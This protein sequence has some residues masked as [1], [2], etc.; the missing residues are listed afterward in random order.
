MECGKFGQRAGKTPPNT[1]NND[2]WMLSFSSILNESG[3]GLIEALHHCKIILKSVKKSIYGV[4]PDDAVDRRKL[5]FF[6]RF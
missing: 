4:I 1:N 3:K 5:G 6:K 2:R